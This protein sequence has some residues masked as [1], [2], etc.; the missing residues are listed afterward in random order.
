MAGKIPNLE[1]FDST[2]FGMTDREA[3]EMDPQFKICHETTFEAIIDAGL[4]PVDLRGSRTGM[5]VGY[6]YN[7]ARMAQVQE[8]GTFYSSQWA[9]D[10]SEAS[11]YF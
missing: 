10:F 5:F 3:N 8:D 7:D 2:F 6:C 9:E 4:D 11:K 1:K